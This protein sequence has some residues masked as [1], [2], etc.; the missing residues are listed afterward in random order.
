MLTASKDGAT[1]VIPLTLV[2]LAHGAFAL[3]R[4]HITPLPLVGKLTMGSLALPSTETHQLHG[5]ERVLVLPRG[6]RSTF[7]VGMGEG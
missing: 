3:P 4:V 6:G 1:H 2:A 5:A 7:V